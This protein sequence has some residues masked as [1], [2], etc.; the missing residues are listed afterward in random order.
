MIF[1]NAFSVSWDHICYI[2]TRY[3]KLKTIRFESLCPLKKLSK[4]ILLK[5]WHSVLFLFAYIWHSWQFKTIN[6]LHY[7]TY[8]HLFLWPSCYS[9]FLPVDVIKQTNCDIIVWCLYRYTKWKKSRLWVHL[10][11]INSVKWLKRRKSQ[12]DSRWKSCISILTE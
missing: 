2:V 1:K 12:H 11:D 10:Q 7:M 5:L 4:W 8:T 9:V 6:Q 3:F